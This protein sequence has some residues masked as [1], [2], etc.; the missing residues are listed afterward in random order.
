MKKAVIIFILLFAAASAGAGDL[1]EIELT[2]GSV[3]A[4]EVVSFANGVYT[5]RTDALGTIS[6]SDS[7][8]KSIRTKGRSEPAASQGTSS[9]DISSLTEKMMSNDEVM[10]L[11]QELRDDPEF[12]K[13]L[14]D[15]AILKAVRTGDTA[16]L[17]AN[18]K[19]LKLLENAKVKEIQEKVSK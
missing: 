2:D 6:V 17:M 13:A 12:Q 7:R 11:I 14:E 5:I 15:P 18:P 19:F 10:A 1:R 3:I 4:G 8:V 9:A 16:M